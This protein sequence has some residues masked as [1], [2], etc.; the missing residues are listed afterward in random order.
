MRLRLSSR[1]AFLGTHQGSM[2]RWIR[3]PKWHL[4]T[5]SV[6]VRKKTRTRKVLRTLSRWRTWE[7]RAFAV[8]RS[9]WVRWVGGSLAGLAS[10]PG[11]VGQRHPISRE[12]ARE[13]RCSIV[14]KLFDVARGTTPREDLRRCYVYTKLGKARHEF[15]D[16]LDDRSGAKKKKKIAP[17]AERSLLSLLLSRE[18]IH[19]RPLK[20]VQAL[21]KSGV[22]FIATIAWAA[23]G[24][25]TK[26]EKEKKRKTTGRTQV[27]FTASI[28]LPLF[29]VMTDFNI[30]ARTLRIEKKK[31]DVYI[32]TGLRMGQSGPHWV[33]ILVPLVVYYTVV[34]FGETG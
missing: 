15:G 10:R 21:E 16:K 2:L 25:M 30:A 27:V 3:Q 28:I 7:S 20:V 9:V 32:S 11:L 19:R 22:K 13:N 1:I 8:T 34:W 5:Q 24:K 26:K 23:S 6:T 12:W 4:L 31:R 17:P 29:F 14:R 18:S 33:R